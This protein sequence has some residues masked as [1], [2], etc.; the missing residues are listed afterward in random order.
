M[1]DYSFLSLLAADRASDP[2]Y[3]NGWLIGIVTGLA[4]GALLAVATPIVLR[5]RRARK[6]AVQENRP[7]PAEELRTTASPS[8][9]GS[10]IFGSP[11]HLGS[12]DINQSA[13]DIY[14]HR[15]EPPSRQ[16]TDPKGNGENDRQ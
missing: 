12:G 14:T 11:V 10:A 5:M 3:D 13:G 2:W 7:G 8:S 6:P 15:G 4:S 16:S 1:M 9:P